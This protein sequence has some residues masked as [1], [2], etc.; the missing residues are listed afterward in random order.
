MTDKN[1]PPTKK[2]K[3][4]RL[5][6]WRR[7]RLRDIFRSEKAAPGKRLGTVQRKVRWGREDHL[8]A[9]KRK[10]VAARR[11]KRAMTKAIQKNRH[12][13]GRNIRHG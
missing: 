7:L 1:Q 12:R 11:A 10:R 13:K 6:L 2:P 9:A 8:E 3:G 4:A 5:S